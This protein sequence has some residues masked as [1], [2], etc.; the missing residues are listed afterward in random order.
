MESLRRRF[1][2]GKYELKD[3]V[4]A[5]YIS[6]I[7][8]A[9]DSIISTLKDPKLSTSDVVRVYSGSMETFSSVPKEKEYRNHLSTA[10]KMILDE[11]AKTSGKVSR[12]VD[13]MKKDPSL[14][15]NIMQLIKQTDSKIDRLSEEAGLLHDI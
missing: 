11:L 2:P 5:A 3:G 8:G 4:K 1:K 12:N 13:M 7:E 6:M 14:L 10:Y 9:R 15:S